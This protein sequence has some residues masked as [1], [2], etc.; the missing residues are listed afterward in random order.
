MAIN[1]LDVQSQPWQFR[2]ESYGAKG[3]M[4]IGHDFAITTGT[5]TLT[6]VG[7]AN[8]SGAPTFANA[9]TGGTVLAGTYQAKITFATAFGETTASP[10]ASTTTAGSTST[11]TVTAPAIVPGGAIGW[12]AYI[13]GAGGSTFFKQNT[14]PPGG[15]P[16]QNNF[17]LTAP[18]NL[19]TAQPPVSNTT[20]SSPWSSMVTGQAIRVVGAG[21]AGADLRTTIL[22]VGGSSATLNANAGTTV[23]ATGAVWGTDDTSAVQS[24]I[25]AAASYTAANNRTGEVILSKLYLSN[26]APTVGGTYAGNCV[27]QLPS[28][29]N[30]AAKQRVSIIGVSKD[31]STLPTYQ[32][33]VPEMSGTGIIYVGPNGTNDATYGAAHVIG[34]PTLPAIFVTESGNKPGTTNIKVMMDSIRVIVPFAGGIGGIDLFSAAESANYNCSVQAL[35]IVPTGGSWTTIPANGPTTNQWGWGLRE[36]GAGNN[37]VS[38]TEQFTCEGLCYGYGPSE[39]LVAIDI[40][41]AYCVTGF[42]C[43]SG[44]GISMVH[45]AHIVSAAAE[46]CTNAVGA[47]DGGIKIDIDNLRTEATSKMLFDPSSR[48]QGTIGVRDQNSGGVYKA[49]GSWVASGAGT[50]VRLI[51]LMTTPG[52]I[53]SPQATVASGSAWFNG[54]FRDAWITLSATTITALTITGLGGTATPVAQNGLAGSPAT[55]GFFLPS[56]CSYTATYTGTLSHTVTLV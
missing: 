32:Q 54:Y 22:S 15:W 8:P 35:G 48:L 3:D 5:A 19:T 28:V 17:T 1:T 47:F 25:N 44:N 50:G 55:Y 9:A 45:N 30:G 40:F 10:A 46:L 43:H 11:L 24:A 13:T 49:L 6:T 56:G 51:N 33:M 12:N 39:H 38:Y 29:P 53:A 23:S 7:V 37:A 21:A 42:E 18:P 20:T 41:V 26:T 16:F 14:T 34:T 36:P 27:I 52:P 31:V 4:A 2:P